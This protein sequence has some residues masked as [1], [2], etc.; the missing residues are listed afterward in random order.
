VSYKLS[1]ELK[2]KRI[3]ICREMLKV[4]K[5][6]GPWQKNHVIA[7][8]E[9]WIYWDN[10]HRGQWTADRAS[11]SPRIHITISSKNMVISGYLTHQWFVSIEALPKTERF[12]YT[13]FSETILLNIVQSVSL[14]RPKMQAQSY[15]MHIGTATVH[16][17]LLSLQKTEEMRFTRLAQPPYSLDL[18]PCGFF[19]FGYL[20]KELHG[21]NFRSQN[22]VIFVVRAF[23]PRSSSKAGT[24]LRRMDREITRVYCDWGEHI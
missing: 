10:Y 13:L 7:G 19:L 1:L 11:V 5:Q 9:C 17:C 2:A 22:E 15:W 24:S 21:K 20:K 14:F 6:L 23:W 18:A 4:L 3:E 16:N 8:N 12:N